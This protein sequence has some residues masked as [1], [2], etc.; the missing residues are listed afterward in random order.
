MDEEWAEIPKFPGY[1][2]GTYGWVRNDRSGR[3]LAQTKNQAD[4][5]NVGLFRDGVQYKRSVPLLVA[6]AFILPP[7]PTFTTPIQLDGDPYNTHVDNLQ[8]RPFW[9]ARSYKQ[10]LRD[11]QGYERPIIDTRTGEVYE[12]YWEAATTYGLLV[13]D[14]HL[15]IANHTYVFPTFQQFAY[16]S[17]Y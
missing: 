15:A 13:R 4:I 2:V 16:A 14:I 3:I 11:R 10:Q 6:R 5:M 9:F 8:W 12:S 1:S 7:K 17:R